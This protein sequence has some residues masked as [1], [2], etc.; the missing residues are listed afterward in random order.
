M[1]KAKQLFAGLILMA[2]GLGA[3]QADYTLNLTK[4]V[5]KVSNDIY[6][7]HM[8]ILWICVIVGIGVFGTMFYSIYHHRKSKGHKAA[9]FMKIPRLKSSGQLF[10]P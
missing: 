4:G 3:A 2:L 9:N 6:D 7:L 5:T 8:L 10:L 1:N